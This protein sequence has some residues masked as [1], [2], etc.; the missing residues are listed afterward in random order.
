MWL[1]F[2]GVLSENGGGRKYKSHWVQWYVC[3]NM[4]NYGECEHNVNV[5]VDNMSVY[6]CVCMCA[7]FFNLWCPRV[8][9][10]RMRTLIT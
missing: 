6:M 10:R 8:K 7:G 2:R 5:L 9:T 4:F 3:P 1:E